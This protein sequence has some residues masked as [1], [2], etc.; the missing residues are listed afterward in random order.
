MRIFW[1]I[2][3]ALPLGLGVPI[4]IGAASVKPEDAASN[5]SGWLRIMGIRNVPD[6]LAS[7]SIDRRV[8]IATI[9]IAVIYS[10]IVW[11]I[12]YLRKH[13]I[14]KASVQNG[15]IPI[16]SLDGSCD[17]KIDGKNF[18]C[19]GKLAYG[20]FT[21][22]RTQINVLPKILGAVGFSGG[23]D[24]Q[25]K[26][27]YYFLT[28]DRLF[29]SGGT[30]VPADGFCSTRGTARSCT[31]SKAMHSPTTGAYSNLSSRQ[32]RSLRPYLISKIQLNILQLY[33]LKLQRR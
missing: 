32:I 26:P 2:L 15:D 13:R 1:Q 21:N 10:S 5:L 9:I 22:G 14:K 8:I 20:H 25:L 4:V 24:L 7:P 6:W 23:K 33:A 29:L 16:V 11:G 30:F 27:E 18:E 17:F 31:W 28:V 12:P 3:K 19:E